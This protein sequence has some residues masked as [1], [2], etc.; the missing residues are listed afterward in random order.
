[1]SDINWKDAPEWATLFGYSVINNRIVWANDD[2]YQYISTRS[3][4]RFGRE[5]PFRTLV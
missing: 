1:M 2:Q 3:I 4:H 5:S